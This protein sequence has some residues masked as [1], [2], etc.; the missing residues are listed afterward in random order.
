MI[1]K[2]KVITKEVLNDLGIYELRELA[3][4]IGVAS[5]TTKKREQLCKEIFEISS[6]VVKVENKTTNK[7]RPPKSVTKISNIVNEYVP[8]EI[9]KLQK[10]SSKPQ[11]SS[12]VKLA[13]NPVR[14]QEKLKEVYGY[15]NSVEGHHYLVNLSNSEIFSGLNFYIPDDIV[16]KY[17]LRNG[18]K[19]SA[20]GR[21]GEDC[22]CGFLDEIIKINDISIQDWNFERKNF[23]LESLSI[24]SEQTEIFNKPIK[25]GERTISIFKNF[26][27]AIIA[28]AQEIEKIKSENEKLIFLGVE[29]APEILFYGQIKKELE[30]FATSYSNTLEESY[31][32][33]IN[34]INHCNTLL[35]DGFNV[36]FF[37]FD[38]VGILTR[39]DQYF[40]SSSK[41]YL[42]HNVDAVQIVKRLIGSGKTFSNS[43]SLTSHAIIFENE[44]NENI[45][46][47]E[48]MKIAKIV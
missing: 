38:A 33:I 36:R 39:L 26:E 31:N 15:I 8:H 43:V 2:E 35:K 18:D 1:E 29:V 41:E 9:L 46:K 20:F 32:A 14:S 10:P 11:F 45:V 23:N 17:S 13:Q 21:L 3:R 42:G 47:N 16:G 37:V 5:P 44:E 4:S 24:P 7:G 25:K 30:M 40:A 12:I 48:F 22:Y 34:S 27:D 28:I 6:G 19:I